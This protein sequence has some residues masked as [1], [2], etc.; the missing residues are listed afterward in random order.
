MTD[1]RHPFLPPRSIAIAIL[2]FALA[3]PYFLTRLTIDNRID[4][5]HDDTDEEARIYDEFLEQFG[6]D[7]FV[8]VAVSGKPL[9]DL[10]GLYVMID[11]LEALEEV[12]HVSHVSGMP[13][14]FRDRFGGEDVEAFEEEMTSTPFYH[15]L[16]LSEDNDVAGFLVQIDDLEA[17]AA[18]EELVE[19]VR[20]AVVPLREF[21]YRVDLV[22]VPIFNTTLNEVSMGAS[23]RMF[24]IALIAAFLILLASLRSIRAAGAVVVSGLIGLMI[25][26]GILGA[27]GK[28]LNIITSAIPVIMWVL[29]LANCIHV[30]CRYQFFRATESSAAQAMNDA[31]KEVRFP[32]ALSAVT[33][34]MGF[35]SLTVADIGPVRD[36]GLMMALGMLV[37]MVVN[38][39]FAP[40]LLILLRTPAPRWS[41]RTGDRAFR[42]LGVV[43]VR[44]RAAVLG[45]FGVV[46]LGGLASLPFVESDQDSSKFLPEDHEA[47][48]AFEFVTENLTG[49]R[50][51]ET[52]VRTP[53]GWLNPDY[54]PAVENMSET[55]SRIEHVSRVITPLDFLKKMNQWD[56]DLS[57]EYYRLPDTRE[58][59]EELFSLLDENDRSEMSR[60]VTADGERVRVSSFVNTLR[61]ADF[62]R[63]RS[64]AE[65]QLDNLPE[66]MSGYITGYVARNEAM[67]YQLVETQVKSLALAFVL[68]FATIFI[69]LR[70]KTIVWVSILPNLIPI[71][72]TFATMAVLGIALDAAT[73]MVASIALGIAVDDT[74]HLLATYRREYAGGRNRTESVLN[75][76]AAVGPAITVTTLTACVGFLCLAQSDFLP[77]AYF[78]LLSTVAM[79]M[80]LAADLFFVPAVL[81]R[82]EKVS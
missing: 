35:I 82:A 80:A 41:G 61:L 21:G 6:Q 7:E 52:V 34:A 50:T 17:P 76:L 48:I 12:P 46:F 77:V 65:R 54:W 62:T 15:G 60:L 33:T 28:P 57:P 73:V 40:Y 27:V 23:I 26:M 69:G 25:T 79:I 13:T 44:N 9:F 38:L 37:T 29:S 20:E 36:M 5:L 49:M 71:V 14:I 63:V 51:L 3:A 68:V 39:Y 10:D 81:G 58:E 30:V 43:V 66:P 70:S 75:A 18:R 47:A 11:V 2:V 59:A 24:P 31:L 19:G 22:G 78:G 4:R 42:R 67:R 55:L 45:I 16:F 64:T 56:H 74:V 72:T 8:I 53:G 32:C 1:R